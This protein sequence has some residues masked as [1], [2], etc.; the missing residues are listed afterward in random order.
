MTNNQ[1]KIARKG[2]KPFQIYAAALLGCTA[3]GGIGWPLHDDPNVI[4]H[5]IATIEW[6][7][8]FDPP[9]WIVPQPTRHHPRHTRVV[10]SIGHDPHWLAYMDYLKTQAEYGAI[11][12][13]MLGVL[14]CLGLEWIGIGETDDP[15]VR[16]SRIVSERALRGKTRRLAKRQHC[17]HIATVPIPRHFEC[18]HTA[19]IGSTGTG[20]STVLR[21]MLDGIEARGEPALVYDSSG[22]FI[23]HY[24]NP[25]RGDVI[26]NP[27]DA[28]SSFWSPFDEISHP[29]D[30]ER[31]AHYLVPQTN[32]ER[33]DVWLE[34]AR[35]L[36]ANI[37]RRLI[38]DN[39]AT[40]TDLLSVLQDK[41]QDELKD[42]VA[43]TSSARTFEPSAEKATA[44]CL[45][46]LA[47]TTSLIKFL[48]RKPGPKGS[49]SFRAFMA[50]LDN[51]QG[52]KPWIFVPRK[53]EYFEAVKPL[54]AA[55][56]ESAASA[57]LALQPS[58][59]R[60]IWFILDEIADLPRVDNL[61]RLL[62]E[63]RKF[64]A[65]VV[66]T[67]Q[68]IGQMQKRYGREG[69]SALLG[70]CNT[71]LFLGLGDFETRQWASQTIGQVEAEIDAS[72]ESRKRGE[73]HVSHNT[74]R[75][76]RPAV[77]ESEFLLPPYQGYLQMPDGLPIGRVKLTKAHITARGAA[78]QD[79]F[80]PADMSR[81]LWG[82]MPDLPPQKPPAPVPFNPNGFNSLRGPI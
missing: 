66:L 53:E 65:G 11:I 52:A 20:K 3:L 13:F 9:G 31:V 25:Q 77:L 60:R 44:S 71:K 59:D 43:G 64:G 57:T 34:T 63:G 5:N 26:L 79:R 28:R 22:E 32:E 49:F 40:L 27:F 61:M 39:R 67:F 6:S 72:T 33:H 18:R 7:E 82:K 70:N 56:L 23:E 55:W 78:E 17:L 30:A 69:A 29:A 75:Q 62:P 73:R 37:M 46:M 48:W 2:M 42:F 8:L 19:L 35:I 68:S 21:Q 16:G 76:T 10:L 36:M 12:G 74:S 51:R 38:A 4:L 41:S 24:Y 14:S 80:L 15:I 47:K 45:F 58:P 1:T 54:M 81:T 50:G